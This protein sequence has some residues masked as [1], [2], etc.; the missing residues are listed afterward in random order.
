MT[1]VLYIC[2]AIIGYLLIGCI[3][4]G[5]LKRFSERWTPNDDEWHFVILL[6]WL[7]IITI[8][9]EEG[10]TPFCKWCYESWQ[11]PNLFTITF[12]KLA[13]WIGGVR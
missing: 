2:G 3:V 8:I 6:W 13:K 10:I 11:W 1:T 9:G 4:T 12:V 5:C 7:A